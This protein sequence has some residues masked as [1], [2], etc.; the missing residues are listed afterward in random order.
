LERAT[1]VL[2]PSALAVL[3]KALEQSGFSRVSELNRILTIGL[4]LS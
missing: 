4:A 3:A 1:T 2:E